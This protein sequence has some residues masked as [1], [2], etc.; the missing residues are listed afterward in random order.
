MLHKSLILASII[1]MAPVFALAQ[2]AAAPRV[3]SNLAQPAAVEVDTIGADASKPSEPG[4]TK[5]A[6]KRAPQAKA[7]ATA[8]GPPVSRE[9]SSSTASIKPKSAKAASAKAPTAKAQ[10]A[11]APTARVQTAKAPTAKG[12]TAKAASAKAGTKVASAKQI[13]RARAI[14]AK[15]TN[16]QKTGAKSKKP[17]VPMTT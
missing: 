10:T 6:P 5:S 15:A 2:T 12:Q 9:T 17:K 11:K 14:R 7:P 4:V 13:A 3:L 16:A 8:K 1:A